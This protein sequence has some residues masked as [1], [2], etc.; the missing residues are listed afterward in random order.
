VVRAGYSSVGMS[1]YGISK[2]QV[3]PYKNT[4]FNIMTYLFNMNFTFCLDI[5]QSPRDG[6]PAGVQWQATSTDY[7]RVLHN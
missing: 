7:I 5:A 2:C 3:S 4:Y 6:N 1:L